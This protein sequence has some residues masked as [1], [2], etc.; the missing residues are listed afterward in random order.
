MITIHKVLNFIQ[1]DNDDRN[2]SSTV[3]IML[4][5]IYI[6]Y[7]AFFIAMSVLSFIMGDSVLIC[8]FVPALL[9]LSCIGFYHTYIDRTLVALLIYYFITVAWVIL[10]L[11]SY[12]WDCGAFEFSFVL[13]CLFYV[14]TYTRLRIKVSVSIIIMLLYLSLKILTLNYT[15]KFEL[16]GIELLILQVMNVSLCFVHLNIVIITFTANS[17][18][19]FKKLQNYNS[20]L[21]VLSS[22]DPLTGLYNRRTMMEFL[23][24]NALEADNSSHSVGIAIG[25]IDF[26]KRFNDC[27]GHECGDEVLKQLA[28]LFKDYM[29]GKGCVAR[30]GGE[31]FLFAF[32]DTNETKVREN[33]E[34]LIHNI[35]LMSIIYGGEYLRVTMTFG[36]NMLDTSQSIDSCVSMADKKL[37][38]G[39]ETG[40]N[41]II[42][43]LEDYL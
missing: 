37:Y 24:E 5:F 11:V 38:Y 6:F 8:L 29:E 39:K 28:A 1:K 9:A 35:R 33:M 13:L 18:R 16:D 17:M 30:W 40:R 14:S 42:F 26:F 19:M 4:R 7:V 25:D 3:S 23:N 2:E 36:V 43:K 27:Y 34:N 41:R 15:P 21:K 20:N 10:S 32:T 31:E 22:T 12:G